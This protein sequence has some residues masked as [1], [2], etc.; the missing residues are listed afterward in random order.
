MSIVDFEKHKNSRDHELSQAR[1]ENRFAFNNDLPSLITT[2]P[3]EFV[4]Y[5]RGVRVGLFATKALAKE[6]MAGP[7]YSVFE[8]PPQSDQAQ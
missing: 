8:I 2:N 4:V 3:G 5:E 7:G 1:Y 6:N